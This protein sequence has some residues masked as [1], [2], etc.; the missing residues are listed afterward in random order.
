MAESL[1]RPA[2]PAKRYFTRAEVAALCTTTETVIHM[3]TVQNWP[4]RSTQAPGRRGLYQHHEVL[5]LRR[6]CQHLH[7][8]FPLMDW[9]TLHTQLQDL[10]LLLSDS[11]SMGK[12]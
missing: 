3:L 7:T 10:R 8:H 5:H 9:D 2:I 4:G 1:T 6:L 11:H 12:D